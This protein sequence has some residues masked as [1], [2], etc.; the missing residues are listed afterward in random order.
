MCYDVPL[1]VA[2]T[3]VVP[4]MYADDT[5][6]ASTIES[7]Q[8]RNN[9]QH[10]INNLEQWSKTNRLQINSAKTYHLS[11]NKNN[12]D[13]QQTI[14]YLGSTPIQ[15]LPTVRDLGVI[16]DQKLTFKSHI[17]QLIIKMRSLYGAAFRFC[18]DIS[19]FTALPK[20]VMT[21]IVP[22]IP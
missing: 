10:S 5:K 1:C 12:D 7:Q 18:K 4:L 21:Y 6:F 16:F 11:F 19:N 2:N 8:D 14:Y 22:V 20:I 13:S 3:D 15:Q 17:D 9:L